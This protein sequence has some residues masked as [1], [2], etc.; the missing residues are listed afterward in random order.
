MI[1]SPVR[2]SAR[3]AAWNEDRGFGF[4]SPVHGGPDVFVHISKFPPGSAVPEVGD[5]L[6]FE[7]ERMPDG[8]L[9]AAAIETDRPPLPKKPHVPRASRLGYLAILGF[10]AIYFLVALL[11][12]VPYWVALIYVGASIVCFAAYALD[13]SAARTG[14]WRVRETSLLAIGLV[15]G[16]PGGILAQQTLRHKTVKMSFQIAFWVTVVLNIV[17][18]LA[19][20]NLV[21]YVP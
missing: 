21:R 14:G 10:M 16:L 11:V 9:R 3:V 20:A 5:H 6:S 18:F 1:P 19:I 12:P 7:I 2:V 17:G 4:A 13:K 8:K 15:G